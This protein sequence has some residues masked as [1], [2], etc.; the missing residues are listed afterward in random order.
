MFDSTTPYPVQAYVPHMD[1]TPQLAFV[2][3]DHRLPMDLDQDGHRE[4]I[5][6]DTVCAFCP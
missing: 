3:A 2:F 5:K 6:G 1:L 4:Q